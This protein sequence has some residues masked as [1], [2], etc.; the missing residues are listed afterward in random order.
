MTGVLATYRTT[1]DAR[2][3]NEAIRW[4]NAEGHWTPPRDRRHADA[5]CCGQA[6]CEIYNVKRDAAMVV[7]LKMA[8]DRM[9]EKHCLLTMD[10]PILKWQ[11]N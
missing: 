4:A 6:Y 5:L 1:G 8:V 2:Y 10:Q 3:L 11:K 9:I 7:P